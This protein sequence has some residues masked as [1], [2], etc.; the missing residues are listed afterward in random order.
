MENPP[1]AILAA[2]DL[3]AAGALKAIKA[4]GL[5]VP[6]DVALIGF[7]DS[8]LST[9]VSPQLTT[10]FL[11]AYEMGEKAYNLLQKH[12]KGE[13]IRE[14]EIL[15]KTELVIRQSCGCTP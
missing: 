10:V 7:D 4:T 8:K 14:P 5:R 1:T 15:L 12:I 6:D 9:L 11:P 3:L 2:G 13:K